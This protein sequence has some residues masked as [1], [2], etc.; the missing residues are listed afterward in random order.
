MR[1]ETCNGEAN[2]DQREGCDVL[3]MLA[4]AGK[5]QTS[6]IPAALM[7]F[8]VSMRQRLRADKLT[9]EVVALVVVVEEAGSSFHA[10]PSPIPVGC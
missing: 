6:N 8:K 2:G 1:S 5:S 3:R 10:E 9:D 7:F 4:I